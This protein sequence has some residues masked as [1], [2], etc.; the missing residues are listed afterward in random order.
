M[1]ETT[2]VRSSVWLLALALG[3]VGVAVILFVRPMSNRTVSHIDEPRRAPANNAMASNKLP[4]Q[5]QPVPVPVVPRVPPSAADAAG[6]AVA[7]AGQKV[8]QPNA[9]Q[10][11]AAPDDDAAAPEAP[12]APMFGP[13]VAGEGIA[14]FPPPGTKPIKRGILVPEDFELPPGYV[15]HYQATDDGE[16]VPAILM[17]HPDYQPVDERGAP[18]KL[19][20]DRV[21]PPEMAP[22]GL[23]IQMLEVPDDGTAPGSTP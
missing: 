3:L 1:V 9:A 15:R 13:L 4:A 11:N 14:V 12:E 17:F 5:Q 7:P 19:P 23:P 22:P 6:G 10:P 8:A 16:R 2:G 20:A 18:I 21:V